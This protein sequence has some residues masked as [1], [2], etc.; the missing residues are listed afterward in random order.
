MA[1]DKDGSKDKNENKGNTQPSDKDPFAHLKIEGES[2]GY[3]GPDLVSYIQE[4]A[5][6]ERARAREREKEEKEREREKEKQEREERERAI[7]RE[8][9]KEAREERDKERAAALE[10]DERLKKMDLD[11]EL[12]MAELQTPEKSK[13]E[14]V[15]KPKLL[16]FDEDHDS[17]DSYLFR[18]EK[19]AQSV[20]LDEDRCVN[21]LPTS[22]KGKALSAYNEIAGDDDFSYIS[23]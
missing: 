16:P 15:F 7:L 12:R 17:M 1:G 21:F 22:L 8:R 10:R 20:G 3:T 13:A 9:E 14:V 18:F 19:Y 11:H 6:E 23:C 4:R 2:L 5:R